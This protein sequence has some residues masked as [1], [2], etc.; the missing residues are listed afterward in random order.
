MSTKAEIRNRVWDALVETGTARFP[1]PPHG[2]IPNF[3]DARAA[4]ERCLAL[5]PLASAR[6]V[7]L[8]PDAPQLPLRAA[9]LHAG[10]TVYVPTPRLR[11]GFLELDPARIPAQERRRAASLSHMPRYARAVSLDEIPEL[12]AI[13]AGSVAVSLDGHRCGK[14]EGYADLEYAVLRELGQPPL[15]VLTTVSELQIVPSIPADPLDLPLA[16]I[17]TPER[18][19][20]VASPPPAPEGIDWSA[21]PEARIAEMPILAE[22]RARRG[23]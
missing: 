1:F 11:A 2:R 7:K 20:E 5:P 12:D 21:L 23:R 18:A 4:A 16:W 3:A 15:P 10:I 9:A 19:H 13:V 17:V 22:L 14:G 8:N 6:R